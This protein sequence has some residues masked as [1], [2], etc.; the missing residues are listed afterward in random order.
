MPGAVGV[1]SVRC[2]GCIMAGSRGALIVFEGCDRV[3]KSTQCRKLVEALKNGGMRAELMKFPG[4]FTVH[5][6][7]VNY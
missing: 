6:I 2:S 1:I 5:G 4:E 7:G 3:G